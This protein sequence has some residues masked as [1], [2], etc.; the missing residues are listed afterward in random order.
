[1]LGLAS[2]THYKN[3]TDII[4]SDI[5]NLEIWLQNGVSVGAAG[6]EDSSG[7]SRDA[8]QSDATM[9]ASVEDGGLLFDSTNPEDFYEFPTA[10]LNLGGT[11]AWTLFVVLKRNGGAA[12]EN[13]IISGDHQD[14]HMRFENEE[15]LHLQTTDAGSGIPSGQ[16]GVAS[17]FVFATDT[18]ANNEKLI[19]TIVKSAVGGYT[20][21]KNG[22]TVSG[23]ETGAANTVNIGQNFKVKHLGA[24]EDGTATDD[25]HF[26]G[27]IYEFILYKSK[28]TDSNIDDVHSYLKNKFQSI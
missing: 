11:V 16:S 5:P 7:N 9:R 24:R 2:G 3:Y 10:Y 4:P 18:W 6:W 25:D 17:K 1:M 21:A 22:Q 8:A 23:I 19:F 13:T 27:N 28:L 14:Q 15:T 20:F 12:D 26:S